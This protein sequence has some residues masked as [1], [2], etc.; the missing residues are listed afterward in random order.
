M[1]VNTA[2]G[3]AL[4]TEWTGAVRMLDRMKNL[5][6]GSF[7][8]H[9]MA[10]PGIAMVIYN[11]PLLLAF[12]VLKQ[13]LVQARDEKS[14]TCSGSRLG[15]L[16]DSAKDSLPWIDWNGLREGVRRR[17]EVAHDG[18]LFVSA[19]AIQDFESVEAQLVAWGIIDAD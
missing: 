8:G 3:A 1:I 16:M 12:D 6:V 13:V 14:F 9:G 7:V 4:S 2:A 17:N 19:Q 11:L 15:A 5:V 10:T 18:K